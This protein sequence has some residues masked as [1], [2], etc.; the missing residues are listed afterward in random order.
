MQISLEKI[1]QL[2]ERTGI[3]Y[4]EAKE[5]LEKVNGDLVEALIYLEERGD[6]RLERLSSRCRDLSAQLGRFMAAL[7][8][9]R[10]RVKVKDN[11]LVELPATYGAFSAR[12]S[13]PRSPRWGSSACFSAREPLRYRRE[14]AWRPIVRPRPKIN[15]DKKG[16]SGLGSGQV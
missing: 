7:H 11:T 15:L 2:R 3:S 13:S 1:E 4:A 10:F 16:N 8:R 9:S 14:A 5:I 12:R 6:S